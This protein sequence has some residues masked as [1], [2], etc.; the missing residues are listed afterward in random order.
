MACD[1]EPCEMWNGD[2]CVCSAMDGDPDAVDDL[3]RWM[4]DLADRED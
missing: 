2:V 4:N 3:T 1:Q